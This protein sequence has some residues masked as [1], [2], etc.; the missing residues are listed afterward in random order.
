MPYQQLLE[1]FG[2]IDDQYRNPFWPAFAGCTRGRGSCT[3]TALMLWMVPVEKVWGKK[4][5]F[6]GLGVSLISMTHYGA[7]NEQSLYLGV[8]NCRGWGAE[9]TGSPHLWNNKL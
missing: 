8:K 5:W 3:S 2:V 9:V 4:G 1:G 7:V 6:Y